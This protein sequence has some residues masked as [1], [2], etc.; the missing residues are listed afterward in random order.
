MPG[1][2]LIRSPARREPSD[3]QEALELGLRPLDDL[4]DRLVALRGIRHHDGVDRLV[5]DLR[6]DV[7][8]RRI[9]SDAG[10]LIAAR[11]IVVDR[12]DRRL[13]LL[14]SIEVVEAL[15]RRQVV[16]VRRR[17]ELAGRFLA[18]D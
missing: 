14:P 5:V 7:R 1:A 15:E 9:A 2:G 13:D 12:T 8:P 6:R 4:V 16:A 10:L 18:R 11:W 3:A 17:D